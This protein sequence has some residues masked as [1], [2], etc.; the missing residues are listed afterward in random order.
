MEEQKAAKEREREAERAKDEVLAIL[1]P[2]ACAGR[3]H[4]LKVTLRA[5]MH[6]VETEGN[7]GHCLG[8]YH[9]TAGATRWLVA[10]GGGAQAG[11]G[12]ARAGGQGAR[13]GARQRC[14]R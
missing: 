1:C 3:T 2:S 7:V 13:Q 6:G 9:D 11:A 5:K 10:A 8:S 4:A 14:R 12:S